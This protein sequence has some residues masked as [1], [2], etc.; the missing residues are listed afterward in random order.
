MDTE[1]DA[2]QRT[3]SNGLWHTT[4]VWTMGISPWDCDGHST[5]PWFRRLRQRSARVALHSAKRSSLQCLPGGQTPPWQSHPLSWSSPPTRIHLA[6]P[7]L[8]LALLLSV[9]RDLFCTTS[10]TAIGGILFGGINGGVFCQIQRSGQVSVFEVDNIKIT[11]RDHLNGRCVNIYLKEAVKGTDVC[12]DA[13]K[14]VV[15]TNDM[16]V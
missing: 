12:L 9:F 15:A 2:R 7:S 4:T 13:K 5:L 16:T 6:H 10:T 11:C 3:T 14:S 8:H 1:L